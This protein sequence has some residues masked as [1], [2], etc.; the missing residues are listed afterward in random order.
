MRLT[1]RTNLAVRVLMFCA[2]HEGR[3]VRSA[4]IASR[5]PPFRQMCLARALSQMSRSGMS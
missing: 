4:Q 1:T 3:I 5:N 2:V